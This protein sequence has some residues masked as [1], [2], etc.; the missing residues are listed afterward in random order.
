MSYHKR[1]EGFV[2]LLAKIL[3][4]A[5][6]P[7]KI[8]RSFQSTRP[9]IQSAYHW[10]DGICSLFIVTLRQNVRVGPPCCVNVAGLTNAT[11]GPTYKAVNSPALA[12]GLTKSK[13]F[14]LH[15]LTL[16]RR[17]IYQVL[18]RVSCYTTPGADSGR[19]SSWTREGQLECSRSLVALQRGRSDNAHR[20]YW[21]STK[22]W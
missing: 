2:F 6:R 8:P 11:L 18:I 3:I 21:E 4:Q 5:I 13:A 20:S 10:L 22:S 9:H 7:P 19:P 12:P 15:L 14:H 17:R 1:L 16:R